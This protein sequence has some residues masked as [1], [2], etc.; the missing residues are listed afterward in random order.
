MFKIVLRYFKMLLILY[1][2]FTSGFVPIIIKIIFYYKAASLNNIH[3][4]YSF[5]IKVKFKLSYIIILEHKGD[6]N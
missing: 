3:T 2:V 1:K 6:K 5:I 4:I